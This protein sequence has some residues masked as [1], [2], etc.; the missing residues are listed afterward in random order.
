MFA[1]NEERLKYLLEKLKLQLDKKSDKI[2]IAK[3]VE[4]GTNNALEVVNA[5]PTGN[6]I[7]INDARL[8]GSGAEVGDSVQLMDG[9]LS[10]ADFTLEEKTL[11][12]NIIEQGGFEEIINNRLD[13]H[14]LVILDKATYGTKKAAGD[15]EDN[16][17]YIILEDNDDPAVINI[18]SIVTLEQIEEMAN[19]KIDK[20]NYIGK[21]EANVEGALKV[22]ASGAVADATK[23]IAIDDS[24]IANEGFDE[25]DFI[26]LEK[27]MVLSETNYDDKEHE[28]VQ[29]LKEIGPENFLIT[30]DIA[31]NLTTDDSVENH[32]R[33]VLS[34]NQ[35]RILEQEYLDQKKNVY[36]TQAEFDALT[37]EAPNTIYH[38]TDA[39]PLIGLTEEQ[40]EMLN[41]AYCYSCLDLSM[42]YAAKD[43]VVDSRRDN[44]GASYRTLQDRLFDI[45]KRLELATYYNENLDD[46]IDAYGVH[47]DFEEQ[48]FT[49]ILRAKNFTSNRDFD[50]VYP[51]AGMRRCNIKDGVFMCYEGEIGYAEDGSNG[52]VMVEIPKFYYKVV[53]VRLESASSGEGQQIVEAKWMI[54]PRALRSFKVHPAFVRNGRE[55]DAVYIGAFEGYINGSTIV[56]IK[57]V[58]PSV[59]KPFSEFQQYVT[60]KGTKYSQIDFTSLSAIQLL[61]LIEYNSFDSQGCIGNGVI[62]KTQLSKTNSSESVNYRGLSDLWGNAICFIQGCV[63]D[64]NSNLYWS[65]DNYDYNFNNKNKINFK[66]P[67]S[68]GF[69]KKIGYDKNNDFVFLSTDNSGSSSTG[70]Y[71]GC[72][73]EVY[74]IG[75]NLT[76]ICRMGSSYSSTVDAGIFAFAFNFQ[77]GEHDTSTGV[78]LQYYK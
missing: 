52:D 77:I 69:I 18:S 72:Y 20:D 67:T 26:L 54:S 36:L 61:F 29:K 28:A 63:I 76:R 9:V 47:V 12:K 16:E 25:G 13:G 46:A 57:D 48:T 49:R 10:E 21:V 24:R 7:A 74:A 50:N 56:S 27:P 75:T 39:E 42:K 37:E 40:V 14:S 41:Q 51:W 53:P 55:V 32:E 11:L 1:F 66:L 73:P 64:S 17:I 5:N 43:E 62:G 8:N 19:N 22:V 2:Q 70:L 58:L 35:G 15:I 6:Q 3:I 71:D 68:T 4:P 78:R 38:I 44:K 65:N 33:L 34:A 60:A 31:D 30:D 45:D 23:E 59:W